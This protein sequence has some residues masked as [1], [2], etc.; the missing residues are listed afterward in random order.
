MFS[1]V[2]LL[3]ENIWRG[4]LAL[5]EPPQIDSA[6]L[7]KAFNFK[8]QGTAHA[9]ALPLQRLG[10]ENI[11]FISEFLSIRHILWRGPR[12]AAPR[13]PLQRMSVMLKNSV[14]K[15][16]SPRPALMGSGDCSH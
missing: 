12:G 3:W 8:T 5:L 6:S 1:D 14:I 10:V 13:G 16:K 9:E 7:K 15:K 2:R 11:F 4:G